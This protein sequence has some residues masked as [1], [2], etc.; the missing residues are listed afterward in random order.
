MSSEETATMRCAGVED[1]RATRVRL[2]GD[3]GVT[4]RV[5]SGRVFGGLGGI[6]GGVPALFGENAFLLLMA[7]QAAF[8]S[9]NI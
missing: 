7:S 2:N 8:K 4:T 5:L 3:F 9:C 6:G 1:F